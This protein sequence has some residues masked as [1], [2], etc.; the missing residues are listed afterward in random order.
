MSGWLAETNLIHSHYDESIFLTGLYS[1]G[2]VELSRVSVIDLNKV[3]EISEAS[4][5]TQ[6]LGPRNLVTSQGTSAVVRRSCPLEGNLG[7]GRCQVNR[8][9]GLIRHNRSIYSQRFW[10]ENTATDCVIRYNS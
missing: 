5:I 8:C 6:L 1:S 4:I 3:H 7:P 9:T 10:R 2:Q